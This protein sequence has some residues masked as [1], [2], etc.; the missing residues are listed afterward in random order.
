VQIVQAA[1]E[2]I[3]FRPTILGAF[4]LPAATV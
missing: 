2:W 3:A 4:A 1:L